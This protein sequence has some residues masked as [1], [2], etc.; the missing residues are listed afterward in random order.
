MYVCLIFFNPIPRAKKNLVFS[1]SSA[2]AVPFFV[3]VSARRCPV[4]WMVAPQRGDLEA[5]R[6]L[7]TCVCAC[8]QGGA[9]PEVRRCGAGC[10]ALAADEPC[11]PQSF[12]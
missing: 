8:A 3:L 12:G 7:R 1:L 4:V 5:A 6:M 2:W 10:F 9:V 11:V